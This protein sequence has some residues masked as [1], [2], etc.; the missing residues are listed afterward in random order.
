MEAHELFS[1][2][3]LWDWEIRAILSSLLVF[4]G[5]FLMTWTITSWN[6]KRAIAVAQT[7]SPGLKRP[8]TLPYYIPFLGHAFQFMGNGG[9]LMSKTT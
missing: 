2:L 4:I 6:A 7:V 8:P 9:R 5:P 3:Q 1:N